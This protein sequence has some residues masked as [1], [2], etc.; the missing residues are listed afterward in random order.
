M[1]EIGKVSEIRDGEMKTA[2]VEGETLAIANIGGSFYAFEDACP[3]I[4]CSL[5]S[6][7]LEGNVVECPCHGSKFDVATGAVLQGPARR[8][9]KA[10]KVTVDGDTLTI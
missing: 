3:H 10:H 9:V 4:G 5:A 1:P 8:P 7:S 6:G 2:E